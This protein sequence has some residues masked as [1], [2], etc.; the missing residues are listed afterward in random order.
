MTKMQHIEC[1][2][3]GSRPTNIVFCVA[4]WLSQQ[5]KVVYSIVNWPTQAAAVY[6]ISK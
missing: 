5:T 2:E 6:A 1:F 3:Q 4:F